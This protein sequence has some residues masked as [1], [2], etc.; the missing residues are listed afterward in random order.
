MKSYV[1]DD[2]V[3]ED[4]VSEVFA[5]LLE[6][7]REQKIDPI[8]PYL[9][10]MLKNKALDFLKQ[11]SFRAEK[12]DNLTASLERE[13]QLRISSLECS[14][15]NEVF[16]TEVQEIIKATLKKLPQKTQEIFILSYFEKKSRK[17]IAKMY[18]I[19]VKG[20]EYHNTQAIKFLKIAMKDY[21]SVIAIVYSNF[22]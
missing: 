9:F 15:P 5:K 12:H 13:L 14:D 18:N 20:V 7:L 10:M 22:L 3:A 4:I 6:L 17:E 1:H 11:Q 21:L 19:T 16:H 8:P 2:A